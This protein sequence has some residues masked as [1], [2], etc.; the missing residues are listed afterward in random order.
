MMQVAGALLAL[1][2][3]PSTLEITAQIPR[4]GFGMEYGFDSLWMVSEGKL[5]RVNPKDNSV[6]DIEL[7]SP[8]N[9]L[10]DIDKYRGLA[11]GEKAVW[12]P[13]I[14]ASTI[15]K[16]D[17][18]RNG[19]VLRI[20]AAL[21]GAEG[22]IAAAFG[23]VWVVTAENGNRMLTRFSSADGGIQAQIDLPSRSTGVIDGF[24]TIWV[25]SS[26]RDEMYRVDPMTNTVSDTIHLD[27]RPRLIASGEGSI[28]ALHLRD[29]SISRID[30]KNGQV[31]K[32]AADAVDNDGD[33]AVGGGFVWVTTRILP[34]IKV[35][36]KN[37]SRVVAYKGPPGMILGRRI[38]YGDKSLWV[39]GGSIYR[40]ALP[41]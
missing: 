10:L 13:D 4:S 33:I 7:G 22:R 38:R 34:V 21:I 25:A 29:G 32:I 8:E 35:D 37:N 5:A 14:G 24:G 39:S 30:G 31:V 3:A 1:A 28:W 23:S 9:T 36:P 18:G 12:V 27:G 19:V 15:Y 26:G 16:I 2:Q 20:S 6:Q 41:Q 40:L 17:P 11:L